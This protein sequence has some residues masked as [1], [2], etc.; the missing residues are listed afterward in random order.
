M[1]ARDLV[2][3]SYHNKMVYINDCGKESSGLLVGA[4][5]NGEYTIIT[6]LA[7]LDDKIVSHMTD[8]AVCDVAHAKVLQ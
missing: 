2:D 6:M 4:R 1:L 3:T 8:F 7:C 5:P